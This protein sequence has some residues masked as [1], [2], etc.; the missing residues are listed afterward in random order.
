MKNFRREIITTPKLSNNNAR[1]GNSEMNSSINVYNRLDSTMKSVKLKTENTPS[2]NRHTHTR[3]CT[4]T[5]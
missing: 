1:N 5:K 3:A 2:D 4:H